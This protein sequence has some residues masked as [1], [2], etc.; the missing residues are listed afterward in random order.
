MW[1]R[2]PPTLTHKTCLLSFVGGIA[3]GVYGCLLGAQARAVF[4]SV[5]VSKF[6]VGNFDGVSVASLARGLELVEMGGDAG[7]VG[8]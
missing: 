5:G 6:G 3:R 2:S 7:D 1:V 8:A 4:F